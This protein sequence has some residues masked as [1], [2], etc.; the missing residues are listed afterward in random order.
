[1]ENKTET[2]TKKFKK[3][4]LTKKQIEVLQSQAIVNVLQSFVMDKENDF[5]YNKKAT[6]QLLNKILNL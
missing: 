4:L 3:L 1:M 2:Q 6:E 5:G